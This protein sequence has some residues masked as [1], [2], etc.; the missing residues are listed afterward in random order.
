MEGLYRKVTRGY[1][2]RIN[3]NYSDELSKVLKYLI[4]IKPIDR[5][6]CSQI[7]DLPI[8]KKKAKKAKKLEVEE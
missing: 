2:S 4:Q 1:Y 6:T 3:K 7:L 5:M 8:V